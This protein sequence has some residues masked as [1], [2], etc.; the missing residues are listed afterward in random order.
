MP[1]NVGNTAFSVTGALYSE[2]QSIQVKLN[3]II[4]VDLLKKIVL[5][6]DLTY[7]GQ[8]FKAVYLPNIQYYSSHD[9]VI[10]S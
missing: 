8:I 5:Y 9:N 2:L 3:K 6:C 4:N 7:M 1:I 10:S